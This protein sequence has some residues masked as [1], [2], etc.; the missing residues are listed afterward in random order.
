MV[1][2]QHLG[3]EHP[4][5]V[6]LGNRGEVTKHDRRDAMAL[7]GVGDEECDLGMRLIGADIGAVCDDLVRR[8][9]GRDEGVAVGVVDIHSPARDPVQVRRAKEAE[10]ERL[11]R[12]TV[13]EPADERL[14]VGANRSEMQRR[15]VSQRNIN[16]VG[17]RVGRHCA[18]RRER[19]LAHS[20]RRVPSG[21][22]AVAGSASRRS[23]IAITSSTTRAAGWSVRSAK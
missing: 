22:P 16:A 10:P 3:R 1:V 21:G 14:V 7:P 2:R 18:A 13:E 23:S 5:T 6:A 9:G 12:D 4:D 20:H 8:T 11:L 15:S 17:P 19:R